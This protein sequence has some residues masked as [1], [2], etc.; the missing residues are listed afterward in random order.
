[1]FYISNLGRRAFSL[2][3]AS[4]VLGVVGLII[5]G[6]WVAAAAVN[7]NMKWRQTEDGLTL[8]IQAIVD[9]WDHQSAGAIQGSYKDIFAW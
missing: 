4:I 2:I 8:Y 7:E 9:A 5:G 1:M 6:I 3:E